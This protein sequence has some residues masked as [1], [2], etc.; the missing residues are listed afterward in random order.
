[1]L[2]TC[3]E[4]RRGLANPVDIA[5]TLSTLSLV[6]LQAGDAVGARIG[7]REALQIFRQLGDRFGE[8]IG[9]LH[10]GQIEVHDG[11]YAQ[12]RS[13][14][15]ACLA[16]AREIKHQEVEGECELV[17]G[18]VAFE[19]GHLE[20]AR[21]RFGRSSTV[22]IEAADKRGEANARWWLA[23]TDLEAGDFQSAGSTLR[24]V[25]QS[26]REFKMQAELLSCLE[27]LAALANHDSQPEVAVR[28]IAA[29]ALSRERLHLPRSPRAQKRWQALMETLHRA[30]GASSF[31]ATWE[32]ARPWEIEDAVRTALAADG[33]ALAA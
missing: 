8:A 3:L 11:E 25:L 27:D 23:K 6:R 19:D 14:L 7:E 1:M 22:C 28:L 20:E 17:L 4:L 12:A 18:E 24:E 9:L 21:R 32:A 16:I 5:A 29:A 10:L 31:D 26:F 13:D 33:E 15:Q 30:L 2:E